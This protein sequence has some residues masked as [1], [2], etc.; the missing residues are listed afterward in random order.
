M[1]NKLQQL[2][3]ISVMGVFV[4][5]GL[6]AWARC[7][8]ETI[9]DPLPVTIT[10]VPPTPSS[11]PYLV[12]EIETVMAPITVVPDDPT[13]TAVL[14]TVTTTRTPTSSVGSESPTPTA[15]STAT[16]TSS[17]GSESPTPTAVST[18]TCPA[19]YVVVRGDYLW[20]IAE[21]FYRD[22]GYWL[23]IYLLNQDVIEDPNLIFAGE[24][25]EMPQPCNR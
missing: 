4:M 21:R 6:W 2:L 3:M 8:G 16:A 5:F 24:R 20:K 12:G 10:A 25:F 9:P 18:A 11:T 1:S 19:Q 23:A 7:G 17:V 14:P 22:G 15:T 13:V